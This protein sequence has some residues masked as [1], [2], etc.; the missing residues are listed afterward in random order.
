MQGRGVVPRVPGPVSSEVQAGNREPECLQVGG[1]RQDSTK[2]GLEG[3]SPPL[4]TRAPQLHP[5]FHPSRPCQSPSSARFEAPVERCTC[6]LGWAEGP[7]KAEAA[8][9]TPATPAV[10]TRPHTKAHTTSMLSQ[11]VVRVCYDHD[12]HT[13]ITVTDTGGPTLCHA[14]R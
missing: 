5:R 12:A 6:L 8:P 9:G 2:C 4:A 10:P 3:T 11:G 1:G 14:L 7:R 13:P